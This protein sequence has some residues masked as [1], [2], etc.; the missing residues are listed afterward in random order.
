M[1]FNAEDFWSG[2]TEPAREALKAPKP[3]ATDRLPN[4]TFRL[5]KT[6]ESLAIGKEL[7]ETG[8]G[9]IVVTIIRDRWELEKLE[10]KKRNRPNPQPFPFGP[11]D[12]KP[13]GV[14]RRLLGK[15]VRKLEESGW[16]STTQERG[17]KRRVT[18]LRTF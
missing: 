17:Q 5:A 8:A 11:A 18:V 2:K 9:L 7:G 12:V 6:E 16:I 15:I 3:V 14:K 4:G 13:Y 10:A 1:N